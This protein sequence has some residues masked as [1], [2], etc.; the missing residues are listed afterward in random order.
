[1]MKSKRE[2]LVVHQ[3]TQRIVLCIAKERRIRSSD[4]PVPTLQADKK[5]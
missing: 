1:M 4:G 2:S 3:F 5:S